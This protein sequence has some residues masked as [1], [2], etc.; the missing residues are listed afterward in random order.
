MGAARYPSVRL[1]KLAEDKIQYYDKQVVDGIEVYYHEKMP[2]SF[3]SL[4]LKMENWL[5]FR[6][7]VA[8]P[9]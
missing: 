7:L 6:K 8:L 4:V 2:D 5:L 1:G 3:G 9:Q